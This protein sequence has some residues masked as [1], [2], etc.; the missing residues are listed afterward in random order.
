MPSHTEQDRT[1]IADTLERR[2]SFLAY[3]IKKYPSRLSQT[4]AAVIR[5]ILSV[6]DLAYRTQTPKNFTKMFVK[7]LE[8][9]EDKPHTSISCANIA[10]YEDGTIWIEGSFDLE[11]LRKRLITVPQPVQLEERLDG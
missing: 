10:V 4:T 9:S 1:H 5:C 7:A 6:A 2:S 8:D 3:F 11:E